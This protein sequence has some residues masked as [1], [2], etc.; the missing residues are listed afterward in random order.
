MSAPIELHEVFFLAP[1]PYGNEVA[2]LT[3]RRSDT[4]ITLVLD[5]TAHVRYCNEAIWGPIGASPL[6]TTDPAA[7]LQRWGWVL[8]RATTGRSAGALVSTTDVGEANHVQ[9]R[10]FVGPASAAGPYRG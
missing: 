8:I 10:L 9:T 5:Q 3:L 6:A 4:Q 7:V 2:V 1:V